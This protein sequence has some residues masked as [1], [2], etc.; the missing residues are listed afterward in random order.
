MPFYARTQSPTLSDVGSRRFSSNRVPQQ[1]MG[2]RTLAHPDGAEIPPPDW[3]SQ[4]CDHSSA[5]PFFLTVLA[6]LAAVFLRLASSAAST[7]FSISVIEPPAFSMAARA[8]AVA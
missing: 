3:L 4:P 5:P 8:P 2:Y 7:F 6:F 1:G